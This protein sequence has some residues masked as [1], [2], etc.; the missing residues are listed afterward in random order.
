M[1]LDRQ[2]VRAKLDAELHEFL[3]AICDAKGITVGE[4]I[5]NLLVPE[6]QRL[7][8]EDTVIFERIERIPTPGKTREMPLAALRGGRR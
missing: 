8:H 4:F 3:L 2:D 1:S 5:E 7:V 6:I